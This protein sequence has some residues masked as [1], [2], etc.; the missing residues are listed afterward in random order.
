M[1]DSSTTTAWGFYITNERKVSGGIRLANTN[2]LDNRIMAY[3]FAPYVEDT[4]AAW[5]LTVHSSGAR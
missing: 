2:Q 5:Y 1:M 4:A 3:C